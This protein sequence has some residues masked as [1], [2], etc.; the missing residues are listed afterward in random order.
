MCYGCLLPFRLLCFAYRATLEAM[1]QSLPPR[2]SLFVRLVFIQKPSS[3]RQ[4]FSNFWV[5][6]PHTATPCCDW[7]ESTLLLVLFCDGVKVAAEVGFLAGF[8]LHR[9]PLLNGDGLLTDCADGPD[10]SLFP[11]ERTPRVVT[12]YNARPHGVQRA[13]AE[14]EGERRVGKGSRG[15]CSMRWKGSFC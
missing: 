13:G 12:T 11:H 2:P 7:S 14:S 10:L 4:L 15:T 9:R 6:H 3:F 8:Q 5:T 1:D